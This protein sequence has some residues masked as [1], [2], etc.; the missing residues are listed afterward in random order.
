MPER[1]RLSRVLREPTL[2]FALGAALLFGIAW[3]F[4]SRA[5]VVEVDRGLVEWE[6]LQVETLRGAP[7]SAAERADIEEGVINERVLVREALALGLDDD[8][9][10]HDLLVQKM[11]H[12]LSADVIQPSEAELEAYFEADPMRYAN[13]ASVTVE[14]LVLL[15]QDALPSSL[16]TQLERGVPLSEIQ[17][18]VPRTGGGLRDVPREDLA[19]IFDGATADAAFA[20]DIGRWVGP[21]LSAR[22][23][24][25]LRTTERTD[26]VPRPLEVVREMVRL[27]WI[28][29]EEE[30]RLS[31]RI[32]EIRERYT[33]V[34]VGGEEGT[35]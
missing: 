14:E 20:A 33:I 27:D 4:G 13:P 29:E 22:G 5:N 6:I 12:V 25:W 26:A 3:V 28:T 16:A 7:L 21:Y 11:L 34:F 15:T 10:I 17:T 32:A 24:H 2:H 1:S 8:E 30:A 31:E 23:Q 19:V 9:R 18:G 35:P